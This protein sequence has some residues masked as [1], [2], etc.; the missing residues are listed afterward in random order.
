MTGGDPENLIEEV[1]QIPAAGL[2]EVVERMNFRVLVDDADVFLTVNGAGVDLVVFHRAVERH[3]FKLFNKAAG[4]VAFKILAGIAG[5][6]GK[7]PFIVFCRDDTPVD[8]NR[9]RL[10]NTLEFIGGILG[11]ITDGADGGDEVFSLAARGLL[12]VVGDGDRG[13]LTAHGM[14]AHA[15]LVLVDKGVG[16]DGII[17]HMLHVGNFQTRI[18][19][20]GRAV[21]VGVARNHN[22]TA[23]GQLDHVLILML[24]I[25]VAAVGEN[26]Q[27]QLIVGGGVFWDID[28]PIDIAAVVHDNFEIFHR[29]GIEGRLDQRGEDAA[30]QAEAQRDGKKDPGAFFHISH[31]FHTIVCCGNGARFLYD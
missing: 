12:K 21:A 4:S 24:E 18:G 1:D 7:E 26:N 31:S 15:D 30:D 16:S 20:R 6:G 28:L 3:A 27:G 13:D 25:V 19:N 17:D 22:E 11:I 23:A 10:L 14:T 2:G 9:D 29:D 8:R 5:L